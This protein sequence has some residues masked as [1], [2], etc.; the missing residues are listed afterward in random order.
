MRWRSLE[1]P[2]EQI[3]LAG[4]GH[5]LNFPPRGYSSGRHCRMAFDNS[6]QPAEAQLYD[7]HEER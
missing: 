1:Y 4:P 5:G 3:L 2:D 6:I 7:Y